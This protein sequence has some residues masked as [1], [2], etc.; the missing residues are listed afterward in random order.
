MWR[1]E[2]QEKPEGGSP[3]RR[4]KHV[5][6]QEHRPRSCFINGQWV[7]TSSSEMWEV[8]SPAT[9]EVIATVAL[10]AEREANDAVEA[11]R[12]A[13]DE[14]PWPALSR[15]ER[16]PYLA[17]IAD[18]LD[19]RSEELVR[20]AVAEQ[21]T[22]VVVAR[23]FVREAVTTW[24]RFA[25]L[26][27]N[28]APA[29]LR[30]VDERRE[31]RV[32]R[33]PVGVV[34]AI[35]PWNGPL[36]LS[37]LKIAAALAAGCAIIAR[38]AAEAPLSVSIL[39]EC[40]QEA[41]VPAGVL[42]LILSDAAVSARLVG[43]LD[44]D[45]VSF[46]GSTQVGAQ[47]MASC[48]ARVARVALELGGKS[49]A[50]ILPDAEPEKVV[51]TLLGSTGLGLAGQV[52]TARTRILVPAERKQEWEAALTEAIAALRIGDPSSEET[53][54]GP[55]QTARQRDRIE[56][57]ISTG[58]EEGARVLTGG[59]RPDGMERGWYVEPTLFTDV[60]PEHT[61]A[62]EE[63]FGPVLSIMSYEDIDDAVRIANASK[64]GLAG[65]VFGEDIEQAQEIA[66]RVR[67]GTFQINTSGPVIAQPF[68]GYKQ[69]GFGREGGPEGIEEFC[70]VKQIQSA[71]VIS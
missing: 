30:P 3:V 34:L 62:Q 32:L 39:V 69:S 25:A 24:R 23:A 58:R 52:C 1:L 21:G 35:T 36:L 27:E 51:P 31:S 10:A 11:A 8:V 64:F 17:R 46:T 38:P 5:L 66:R 12:R 33:E 47:I 54:V 40:A 20:V 61:I 68:G 4:E 71:R 13:F 49:A 56:R 57:Y 45:M 42:N 37:S 55:V 16:A 48:A 18:A 22:P 70:Q 41:G 14:S 6:E 43:H 65:S 29:E 60:L 53:N 44:V 63:I 59:G 19:A 2:R 15:A 67:V 50:V 28:N 7:A 9:G 26:A